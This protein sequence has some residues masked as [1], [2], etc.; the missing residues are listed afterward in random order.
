[1]LGLRDKD[2][3]LLNTNDA[4]NFSYK[5]R[6]LYTGCSCITGQRTLS[7]DSHI[8]SALKYLRLWFQGDSIKTRISIH[9]KWSNVIDIQYFKEWI[10]SLDELRFGLYIDDWLK[11]DIEPLNTTKW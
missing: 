8:V 9:D 4:Y 2:M 7:P 11:K 6:N 5:V 3:E 10:G 1:M